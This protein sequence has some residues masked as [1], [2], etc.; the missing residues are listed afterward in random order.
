MHGTTSWNSIAIFPR[1][2]KQY[3][4]Q[5]LLHGYSGNRF[6]GLPSAIGSSITSNGHQLRSGIAL[7]HYEFTLQNQGLFDAPPP[8]IQL[9]APLFIGSTSIRTD[10]PLVCRAHLLVRSGRT[11]RQRQ[12]A[13]P[14]HRRRER[15]SDGTDPSGGLTTGG[16]QTGEARSK[17]HRGQGPEGA[18]P[19]RQAPERSV[20]WAI[21]RAC[22]AWAGRC[23]A[24]T[25]WIE[26]SAEQP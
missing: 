21:F 9:P 23:S 13:W 8:L 11:A 10:P 7:G 25:E 2:S 19:N 6:S 4:G 24:A 17:A 16:P 14:W 12:K 1:T 3:Y 20:Q 18:N 15:R 22:A 26:A 5:G